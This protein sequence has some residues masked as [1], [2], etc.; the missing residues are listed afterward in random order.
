VS[1]FILWFSIAMQGYLLAVGLASWLELRRHRHLGKFDRSADM[2]SSATTPPVSI[3][4]PAY[5]EAAGIVDSVRSMSMLSYPRFE[6]VIVNDGSTDETLD[7][8]IE[9]FRMEAISTPYRGDIATAPVRAIYRSR[10]PLPIILV[11]KENGGRA[12]AINTGI[13]V[14]RYPYVLLTD[15][16]VVLDGYCLLRAMR[17]VLEDRQ[18]TVAVGGNVRPLNGANVEYGKVTKADLGPTLLERTQV[19]EYVRSFVATRPGWSRFNTMLLLSGAFGLFRRDVLTEVG[20]LSRGHLGEDLDVTMRIH[21]HLRDQKRRYRIVYAP[22]AVCWTEVPNTREVLSRQRIRWHR[23]LFAA[24]RDFAPMLGN[25]RYGG[26]GLVA[27]PLFMLF[28]FVAPIIEF[29]GWFVIPISLLSGRLNWPVALS[30]LLIAYFIGA[31]NSLLALLLDE[32]FGYFSRPIDAL[33]LIG[34]AFLENLG[35]R[36][37]TVWWRTRALWG[38]RS[39]WA[40]GNMQRRGVANLSN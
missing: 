30:L 38:G 18:A 14:S 23:G 2:L 36:Q 40:W 6:I 16:D 4:V 20:G 19:L 15:A 3:I 26:L 27:W 34:V 21:R 35:M 22:D 12:D 11:D 8:M 13:N 39:S 32:A 7:R 37:R 33:R 1:L 10:L 5:N 28:E 25:P 24:V 31:A 9:A 17:H 29:I